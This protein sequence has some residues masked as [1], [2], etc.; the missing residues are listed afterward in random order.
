[1][2]AEDGTLNPAPD[3]VHDPKFQEGGFFD[4]RD[5]VQV[6]YEMLRR[7]SIEKASVTEVSEEY[8][9][10][11]PTFYQ[12]RADFEEGGV[13][14]LVPK[15]RG[16]RG[17][18]KIRSDV[19]AFLMAQLSPGE[20]IRARELAKL[21]QKEFGLDVHPRTIERAIGGKKTPR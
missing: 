5:A 6:K 1:M 12:A 16:P 17:P 11:R 4:P 13:A 8:G 3:K 18:H 9:I 19:L 14:G 10:S 2:L 20:P 21:I 15:K 7:A